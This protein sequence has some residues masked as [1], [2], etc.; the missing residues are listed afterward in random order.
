M[1]TI[2]TPTPKNLK[3]R[4]MDEF[5]ESKCSVCGMPINEHGNV[6]NFLNGGRLICPV[7]SDADTKDVA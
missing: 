4:L 7:N 3:G 1:E 6:E 2:I 5:S